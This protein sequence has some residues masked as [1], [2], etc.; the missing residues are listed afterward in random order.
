MN[1]RPR[2]QP[3]EYD[4][5]CSSPAA[6]SIDAFGVRDVYDREMFGKYCTWINLPENRDLRAYLAPMG[7]NF[8]NTLVS[9]G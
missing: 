1:P 5:R 7:P 3:S 4:G 2:S 6:G 8:L 9:S